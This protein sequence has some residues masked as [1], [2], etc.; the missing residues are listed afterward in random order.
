MSSCP[1]TDTDPKISGKGVASTKTER[2][3]KTMSDNQ[4]LK[5][6]SSSIRGFHVYKDWWTPT[7]DEILPSKPENSEDKTQSLC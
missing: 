1:D 2:V 5:I 3:P 4:I 7:C 6:S